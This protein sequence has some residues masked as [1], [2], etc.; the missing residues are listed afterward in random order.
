MWGLSSVIF[1]AIERNSAEVLRILLDTPGTNPNAMSAS[2]PR[3]PAH[4]FAIISSKWTLRDPTEVVQTLLAYGANP[5]AIP[6]FFWMDFFLDMHEIELDHIE[7][8]LEN[9]GL[10]VKSLLRAS[11]T[12][13]ISDLA[14]NAALIDTFHLTHR[15]HFERASQVPEIDA[16]R[17]QLF[18]A[19]NLEGLL[20][21]PYY[22]EQ[23]IANQL[24]MDHVFAHKCLLNSKVPLV[25]AFAGPSGHGQLELVKLMSSL[26]EAPLKYVDCSQIRSFFSLFTDIREPLDNSESSSLDEFVYSLEGKRAIVYLDN[27]SKIK[28]T[29][30]D[31]LSFLSAVIENG[32]YADEE[33]FETADVSK[34]IWILKTNL[35]ESA[36]LDSADKRWS[37]DHNAREMKGLQA[38]VLAAFNSN[39]WEVRLP[40]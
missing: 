7:D 3:L 10:T 9:Q 6:K 35:G 33:S 8:R 30:S 23:D 38:A 4:V 5:E 1:F 40:Y 22:S 25:M 34:I 24:V 2:E 39:G 37:I 16:R 27:C 13:W 11:E 12:R 28:N 29:A 36:V 32:F 31:S 26:L 21:L 14:M 19:F 15:F 18:K 20:R 17:S